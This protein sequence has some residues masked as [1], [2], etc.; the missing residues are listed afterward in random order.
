MKKIKLSIGLFDKDTKKQQ[1]DTFVAVQLIEKTLIAVGAAG[2]SV[3]TGNGVYVHEDGKLV[4]EPSVFVDIYNLPNEELEER[5][6][7]KLFRAVCKFCKIPTGYTLTGYANHFAPEV[8]KNDEN[9]SF[10]SDSYEIDSYYT[11]TKCPLIV[12]F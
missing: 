9:Y 5:N 1:I 6:F 10:L 4:R 3:Y 8:L 12:E 7:G 11:K 2:L